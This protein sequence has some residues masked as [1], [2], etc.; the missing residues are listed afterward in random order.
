[1]AASH[2][3]G[4]LTST[5]GFVGAVTGAITG[6]I[7]GN[8]TGN[9]TGNV[10][11][12]VTGDI[13]GNV[14]GNVTGSI[15][16]GNSTNTI[17][18]V[19]AAIVSAV[20][21]G[22]FSIAGANSETTTTNAGAISISKLMTNISTAGAESRTLAAP[23]AAGQLKIIVM[24]VDGGDCTLSLANVYGGSAATTATFDDVGDSLVLISTGTSK[25]LVLGNTAT[26]S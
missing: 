14:T 12:N 1:M 5:N 15:S 19:T 4:P 25:W 7:T 16:G 17:N 6:N 20:P 26:L 24:S 22:T 18:S 13:T 3:S 21:N 2:I 23:S 9:L 8:V 10:T 11:G